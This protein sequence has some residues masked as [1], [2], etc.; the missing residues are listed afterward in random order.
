MPVVDASV[1]VDWVA[2]N[3]DPAL[4]ALAVLARLTADDAELLAHGS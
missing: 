4:P 1:V 3:A 2:P